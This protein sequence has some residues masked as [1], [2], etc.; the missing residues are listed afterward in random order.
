MFYTKDN[1][2]FRNSWFQEIEKTDIVKK[3]SQI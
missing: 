3:D 2:N 1:K